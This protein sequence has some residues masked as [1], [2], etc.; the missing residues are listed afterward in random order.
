MN[1]TKLHSMQK[2]KHYQC[3]H[4]PLACQNKPKGTYFEDARIICLIRVS[5]K[6]LTTIL[7]QFGPTSG[8]TWGTKW[9]PITHLNIRMLLG[10]LFCL[11]QQAT[12]VES[13]LSRG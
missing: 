13:V 5:S 6:R 8:P 9:P 7:K 2:V 12:W 3:K 4:I 11:S 10:E 1:Q